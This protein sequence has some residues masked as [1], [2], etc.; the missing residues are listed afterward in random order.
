MQIIAV[1]SEPEVSLVMEFIPH[2]SLQCYL[3]INRDRLK[4]QHLLK[5][6]LDVAKVS[7]YT[8]NQ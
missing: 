7:E 8:R 6:A 4:P 1:I 2:G 5:F 3:K